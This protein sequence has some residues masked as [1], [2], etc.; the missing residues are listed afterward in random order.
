[1]PRNERRLGTQKYNER[2]TGCTRIFDKGV[3]SIA[4]NVE[5]TKVGTKTIL[6]L[7]VNIF[8]QGAWIA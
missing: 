5:E 3:G 6:V 1:L 8:R 7:F 2:F 4:V